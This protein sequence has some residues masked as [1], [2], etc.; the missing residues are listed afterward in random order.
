MILNKDVKKLV[1]TILRH[2]PSGDICQFCAGKLPEHLPECSVLL[3][4]DMLNDKTQGVSNYNAII[5][6]ERDKI[7]QFLSNEIS[8][9]QANYETIFNNDSINGM[10][11]LLRKFVYYKDENSKNAQS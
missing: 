3:A 1:S 4:L 11:Y 6:A 5:N 9:L 10:N 7:Y 2:Y 8:K